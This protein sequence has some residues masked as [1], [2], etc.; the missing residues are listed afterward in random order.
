MNIRKATLNDVDA[1]QNLNN[2][3]FELECNHYDEYLSKGWTF[4]GSGRAF[5]ENVIKNDYV[6]VAEI[7]NVTV[8]YLHAFEVKIPYYQFDIAEISDLCVDSKFRGRG[9]GMELCKSFEEH[10]RAKGI[11]H[12]QMTA[13]FKNESA[14]AFYRKL[15]Y[16]EHNV[17]LVKF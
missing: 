13:S 14:R 7:D 12:F 5:F 10:Y 16:R 11:K 1:I 6:V 15:G 9:I 4:E 17:T 8:G 3:L 2:E